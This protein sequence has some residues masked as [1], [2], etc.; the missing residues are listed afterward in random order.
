MIE[1][2]VTKYINLSLPKTGTTSFGRLMAS[3]G[4]CFCDGNW[5]DYKTNFLWLA[6]VS[7]AYELIDQAIEPFDA[8]SDGPFGGTNYYIHAAKHFS[9][10]KYLLVIR[11]DDDWW[12]SL[13]AMIDKIVG[14]EN[15]SLGLQQK[16][17]LVYK[18]GRFGF[19]IWA[20]QFCKNDFSKSGFTH[21]KR[22]YEE[23]V[24]QHF[25]G[26]KNF[27]RLSF[28]AFVNNEASEFLGTAMKPVPHANK[29]NR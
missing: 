15:R 18:M 1:S 10:V 12:N 20:A 4:K 25:A 24:S 6:G 2:N 29:S 17:D 9:D 16:I 21:A 28:S 8:M 23:Q 13:D 22:T 19:A 11:D 3:L 27:K 14:E 26:Q 7:G 5:K